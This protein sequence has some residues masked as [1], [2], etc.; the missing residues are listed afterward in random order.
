MFTHLIPDFP[1][2]EQYW[3][4]TW[5]YLITLKS[6]NYLL[7]VDLAAINIAEFNEQHYRANNFTSKRRTIQVASG[8][9]PVIEIGSIWHHQRLF[10]SPSASAQADKAND[11]VNTLTVTITS[12]KK[13][14]SITLEKLAQAVDHIASV[15]PFDSFGKNLLRSSPCRVLKPEAITLQYGKKIG[16]LIIPPSEILR[17]YH[18]GS[19]SLLTQLLAGGIPYDQVFLREA[20][21]F[22]PLTGEL[23]VRIRGHL[24]DS[25]ALYAGRLAGDQTAYEEATNFG[26]HIQRNLINNGVSHLDTGLPFAGPT[27]LEVVGKWIKTTA[28]PHKWA[29]LVYAILSCTARMPF[30]KLLFYRENDNTQTENPDQEEQV[31]RGTMRQVEV[32]ASGARVN[33]TAPPS[34]GLAQG[35]LE[36]LI[37]A[38][39]KFLQSPPVERIKKEQQLIA[40]RWRQPR[41]YVH[42]DS[43]T[44]ADSDS[45]GLGDDDEFGSVS[46][47]EVTEPLPSS[48][49]GVEFSQFR[50]ITEALRAEQIT[51]LYLDYANH[52]ATHTAY[53]DFPFPTYSVTSKTERW[54]LV[55]TKVAESTGQH[56]SNR[57]K[58]TTRRVV[59]LQL[60]YGGRRFYLVECEARKSESF[61]RCLLTSNTPVYDLALLLGNLFDQL[62]E[63]KGRWSKIKLSG[64]DI[65]KQ[66]IHHG[67]QDTPSSVAQRILGYLRRMSEA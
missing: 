55:Q 19:D 9:L 1:K 41:W 11:K 5:I 31:P 30:Q 37:A 23:F 47:D 3:M 7:T 14:L 33:S 29:F 13:A 27:K 40:R 67:K 8:F 59:A 4:V 24:N 65:A 28:G 21:R 62:A 20:T 36:L 57:K 56:L 2:D 16:F 43:Y 61:S 64:L 52:M 63:K 53:V 45:I 44:L 38:D 6:N 17:F 60:T 51:C 54:L 32:P 35:K 25:D 46:T 26:K 34:P 42:P 50:E 48:G 49:A 10:F 18:C 22:N 15:H 58:K 39:Q 12:P 66:A